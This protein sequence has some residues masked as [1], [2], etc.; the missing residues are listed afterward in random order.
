[1]FNGPFC[2]FWYCWPPQ[3][4]PIYL[5]SFLYSIHDT[6]FSLF[7]FDFCFLCGLLLWFSLKPPCSWSFHSCPFP[8][9][10]SFSMC[11]HG[12]ISSPVSFPT[13]SQ[14]CTLGFDRSWLLGSSG[15]HSTKYH[16][17]K[18]LHLRIS[19]A[20][21]LKSTGLKQ[22]SSIFSDLKMYLLPCAQAQFMIPVLSAH[23]GQMSGVTLKQGW[24]THNICSTLSHLPSRSHDIVHKSFIVFFPAELVASGIFFNLKPPRLTIHQSWLA[25]WVYLPPPL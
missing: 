3:P 25:T 1:M 9:L 6:V 20:T 14:I 24:Q 22:N 15:H 4:P 2:C 16:S 17:T 18:Y 19:Q 7:S 13:N 21:G 12:E 23:S 8:P 10:F 5:Q 11:C